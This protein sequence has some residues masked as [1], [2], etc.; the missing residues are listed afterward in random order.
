MNS[1]SDVK[2]I[3]D[4]TD[5]GLKVFVHY[6]GDGC[7]NKSF[8]NPYRKDDHPSCRL[9]YHLSRQGGGKWYLH[10]Y[11]DSE[12][13]GDCFWFVAKICGLNLQSSFR[14]VLHVIDKDLNIFALDGTRDANFSYT[15]MARR[16]TDGTSGPASKIVSFAPEFKPFSKHELSYWGQYGIT[17]DWLSRLGVRS[18]RHCVYTRADGT[19]FEDEGTYDA[20]VFAYT[21]PDCHSLDSV[22]SDS[23]VRGMKL[24]RPN[25]STKSRFMYVGQLPHPYIFGSREFLAHR[26]MK[27]KETVYITG[28][29]K[30][31]LSLLS[32]GFDA[33]CFNS[34]T[35]SIP[36][37]VMKQLTRAYRH[38]VFLYDCD[39]T[40]VKESA[41]RVEAFKPFYPNVSRA[42]LPLKGTKDEKDISDFFRY[43]HSPEELRQLTFDPMSPTNNQTVEDN[44]EDLE[45]DHSHHPEQARKCLRL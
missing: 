23:T 11:G 32:H 6:L 34:E 38:V 22:A 1:E 45:N 9:Y 43:G 4:R 29:E 24:Y 35:A 18:V 3:L 44:Y 26:G 28:G 15:M 25:S 17:E 20:P 33:V 7:Q 30:D 19:V 37:V 8:R 21:F 36:D 13:H 10:D 27:P 2:K 42:V 40:G 5:D 41:L 12:W 16:E 14:D 31:V 39:A